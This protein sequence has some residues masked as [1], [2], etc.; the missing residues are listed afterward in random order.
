MN[1]A[2]VEGVKHSTIQ[3]LVVENFI[4][5]FGSFFSLSRFGTGQVNVSSCLSLFQIFVGFNQVIFEILAI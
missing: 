2:T 1:C 3:I 4:L 5:G